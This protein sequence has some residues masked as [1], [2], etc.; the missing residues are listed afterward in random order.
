MTH[1]LS[2]LFIPTLA[3]F[4]LCSSTLAQAQTKS[5][6]DSLAE[7]REMLADGNPADLY[8]DSGKE[9]WEAKAGSKNLSLAESCDLGLGVGKVKGASAQL[10]RYFKDTDRVQDL[11]SRLLSC[12]QSAQGLDPEKLINGSD[13]TR[14]DMIALVTYIVSQSKGMKVNVSLSNQKMK[15]LYDVGEK[16]FFY[17]GGPFD[18]SCATC[19]SAEGGRIRLQDL[20]N[21]TT[22]PGAAMGWGSWPAYRVSN[23]QMW[24]MQK[25]LEDCF[26]QQRMPKPGYTSDLTIAL[27]VYMA[28]N[29]NGGVIQ[30]PAIKR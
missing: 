25:R 1:H 29:A 20:P 30:T 7:Y 16:A 4:A 14:A 6:A 5:S 8:A 19:H 2:K 22:H 17:R 11:E 3:L 21:I 15:D 27:S 10:P 12:M 28:K 9:K 23:G 13:K 26:R 24:T 18:F